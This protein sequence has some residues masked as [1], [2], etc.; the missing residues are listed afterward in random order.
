MRYL[1]IQR[2]WAL[3]LSDRWY[4]RYEKRISISQNEICPQSRAYFLILEEGLGNPLRVPIFQLL[5]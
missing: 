4:L 2:I 1:V 3:S 5:S